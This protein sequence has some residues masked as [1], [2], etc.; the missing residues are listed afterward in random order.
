MQ[1]SKTGISKYF[2]TWFLLLSFLARPIHELGHWIVYK[3]YGIDVYFTLNQVVPK[4]ISNFKLLGE[5]GGP[6]INVLL[7]LLGFWIIGRRRSKDLGP[8]L[9]ITNSLSRLVPYLIIALTDSWTSNDEGIVASVLNLNIYTFYI[10]LGIFFILSIIVCFR[11]SFKE[12]RKETVRP[13]IFMVI[14]FTLITF[15]LEIPQ[16]IFFENYHLDVNEIIR[17]MQSK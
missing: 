2:W 8:A 7:I 1:K 15:I 5:A 10:I 11:V 14:I 13:L 16:N 17:H 3:I 9:I 6:L 4:E 12:S